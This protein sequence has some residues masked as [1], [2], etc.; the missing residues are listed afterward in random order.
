MPPPATTGGRHAAAHAD[1]RGDGH[2][3]PNT[4][5]AARWRLTPTGDGAD[6]G[7]G[8]RGQAASTPTTGSPGR[9]RPATSSGS[10][11][12]RAATRSAQRALADRRGRRSTRRRSCSASPRT[13]P[14]D[15][16]IYADQDAFYDALG[17][18][19]RE[20]VGGQ[21][22]AEIRTLFALIPP[23]EIDDAWVAIVVPHEL[24]PPRLR[25]RGPQPVP[26]PAALAQRGPGGLPERRATTPSD[27][28]ARRGARPSAG[29]LIPLDGLG[30]QFPTTREGFGLAYAESVSAVDYFV[31][32]LRPGRA[33][34]ADPLVRGRADRR[35]GVHGGDRRR[36][37]GVRRRLAGRPGRGDAES[38]TGPQ[39]AP[40][41]PVPPGW[42]GRGRARPSP[43]RIGGVRSRRR[44]RRAAGRVARRR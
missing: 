29:D 42:A 9:P 27:R 41:G 21:A 19:T 22:N 40:P 30:G 10:T 28:R 35:R 20:N 44:R 39:P 16:F 18:G 38:A 17:P 13:E 26:L 12:T 43:A 24:D 34:R 37:R 25:H 1:A 31:R 15:F 3:L 32:T 8:P 2:L 14:V 23:G 6:A 4:P 33:G 5:V 36:R 11:G 7:P